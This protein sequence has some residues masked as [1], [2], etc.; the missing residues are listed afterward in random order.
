MERFHLQEEKWNERMSMC[1]RIRT[2]SAEL[3][4]SAV[5]WLLSHSLKDFC[6][7]NSL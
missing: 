1:Y 7:I 6:A 2:G 4:L 3:S 5:I